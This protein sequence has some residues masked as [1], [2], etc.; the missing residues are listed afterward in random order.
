MYQVRRRTLKDLE[1]T[2]RQLDEMEELMDAQDAVEKRQVALRD[3]HLAKIEEDITLDDILTEME[4]D[5]L[6][7]FLS[8]FR[9]RR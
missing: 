2:S 9:N 5:S 4:K 6:C 3:R 7:H 8:V 1:E